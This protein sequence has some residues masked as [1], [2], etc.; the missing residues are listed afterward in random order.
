MNI[1]IPKYNGPCIYTIWTSEEPEKIYIGK[2][3]NYG[4]RSKR[5][6]TDLKAGRHGNSYLQRLFNKGKELNICP[7]EVCSKDTLSDREKFW[8]SFYHTYS[9]GYNLTKGGESI[10]EELI[11]WSEERRQ[12]WSKHCSE[13]PIAKGV[14]RSDVWKSKMKDSIEARRRVGILMQHRNKRC[15]VT[16]LSTGVSISYKNI[17]MAAEENKLNYIHLTERIKKGNGVATVKHFKV[18]LDV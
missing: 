9:S 3:V 17:K 2:T 12:A 7:M 10:P 1:N 13:N 18:K 8:V 5:H 6:L 11:T 16:N 15:V 4:I 14:K